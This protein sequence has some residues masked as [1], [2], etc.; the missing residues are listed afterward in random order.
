MIQSLEKIEYLLEQKNITLA[1]L[2][3]LRSK[4]NVPFRLHP[5]GFLACTLL[6]EG[7]RK[8]RLHYWPVAGATQQSPECQIH[9]HLFE[10]RSWVLTGAVENI[11]YIISSEGRELAVYQT[12]Y[13]GNQSILSKMDF[14]LKLT[15]QKRKLY[16]AGSSYS[17]SAGVL[18]ETVRLGSEPVFTVLVTNDVSTS[19]P[20]VLGPIN[21]QQQYIYERDI[22]QESVVV[23]M[24]AEAGY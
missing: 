22:V 7:T 10:F 6:T 18:H 20:V 2:L 5:L 8:L 4:L 12:E 23:A 1:D 9:D 13:S 14:T 21:G 24:L 16:Q 11:E 19:A 15:E 17:M 3:K